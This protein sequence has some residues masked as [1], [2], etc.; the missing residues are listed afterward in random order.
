M[1]N[2]IEILPT[3][4]TPDSSESD[5]VVP[6]KDI[7]RAQAQANANKGKA[8]LNEENETETAPSEGS[9]RK[10]RKCGKLGGLGGQQANIDEKIWNKLP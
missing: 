8:K 1:F 3:Y 9:T 10:Q 2:Y 6:L 7:T 5:I 4:N